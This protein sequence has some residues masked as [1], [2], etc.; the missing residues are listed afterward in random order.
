MFQQDHHTEGKNEPF[1]K[2]EFS[3][4]TILTSVTIY[5]QNAQFFYLPS[6]YIS[7]NF[8]VPT[9]SF[10]LNT[11]AGIHSYFKRCYEEN[12]LII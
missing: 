8:K 4:D 1:L 3:G 11:V 10:Q 2:V 12:V 5:I 9:N 6:M 7:A